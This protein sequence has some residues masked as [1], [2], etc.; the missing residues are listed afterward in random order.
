MALLL[1]VLALLLLALACDNKDNDSSGDTPSASP[2]ADE[3]PQ[4]TGEATATPAP[5]GTPAPPDGEGTPV[6]LQTDVPAFRAQFDE[7]IETTLPCDYD[8]ETGIVDCSAQDTD[9]Y[10]L[11]E[12]L[13]GETVKCRAMIISEGDVGVFCQTDPEVQPVISADYALPD[14]AL[15]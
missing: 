12:P 2:S 13:E 10:L 6:A 14:Y 3:S 11:D 5:D 9:I 1:P 15:D 4:A 7:V 8:Q